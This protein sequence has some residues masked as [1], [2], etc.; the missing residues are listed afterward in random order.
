M[1]A[2]KTKY[3]DIAVQGPR[4]CPPILM[5]GSTGDVEAGFSR[6]DFVIFQG[7]QMLPP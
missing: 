6:A 4:S 3:H 2:K 5:A 7:E 1:F